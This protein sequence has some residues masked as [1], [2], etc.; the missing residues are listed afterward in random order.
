[1]EACGFE[2]SRYASIL[3]TSY[4]TGHIGMLMGEKKSSMASKQK[5][6]VD[7]YR[8]MVEMGGRTTY[9]QPSLSRG[10]VTCMDIHAASLHSIEAHK[11]VLIYQ[12]V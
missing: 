8:K 11:T 3:T 7:R 6:I 5:A 1:M 10:Y 9:Y 4:P 12:R 2:R